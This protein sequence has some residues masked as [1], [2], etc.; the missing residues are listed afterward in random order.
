M[1]FAIAAL[2]AP[3]MSTSAVLHSPCHPA[4]SRGVS[5]ESGE[6]VKATAHDHVMS[7]EVKRM[8]LVAMAPRIMSLAPALLS[9][10]PQD[11]A[12]ASA[13][14]LPSPNPIPL[15]HLTQALLISA[16]HTCM[17]HMSWLL[18]LLLYIPHRE[19]IRGLGPGELRALIALLE[20]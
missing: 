5:E 19:F 1:C 13:F 12:K 10:S 9:M 11:A 14:V 15:S 3:S 2:D 16:T 20:E 6:L 17:C 7:E 4:A 8:Q 18:S